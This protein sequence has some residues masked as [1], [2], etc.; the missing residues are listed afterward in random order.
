MTENRL[1]NVDV[2][3]KDTALVLITSIAGSAVGLIGCSVLHRRMLRVHDIDPVSI[4]PSSPATTICGYFLVLIGFAA[5]ALPSPVVEEMHSSVDFDVTLIRNTFISVSVGILGVI[6]LHFIFYRSNITYWVVL[7]FLQGGLAS[8][9]TISAGYDLYDVP[10]CIIVSLIGAICFFFTSEYFFTTTIEDNCNIIAIHFVCGIV[11][12]LL[13]PF[14]SRKGNLGFLNNPSV[15]MNMIHLAWQVL[16]CLA[17]LAL[18]FL[19]FTPIFLLLLSLHILRNKRE[20]YAHERARRVSKT[21]RKLIVAE[22][23]VDNNYILPNIDRKELEDDLE[24]KISGYGEHT[25]QKVF[26]NIGETPFYHPETRKSCSIL[27]LRR[28]SKVFQKNARTPKNKGRA[29]FQKCK[30]VVIK[31]PFHS[32]SALHK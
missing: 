31:N 21:G 32:D 3:F 9:I 4:G 18:I 19:T 24:M 15:Y 26:Q 1:D 8:F 30:N 20:I 16:C 12:C 14:F 27:K 7:K 13:P 23:N 10:M 2:S 5:L 28:P 17:A 25:T 29:R 6:V 11:S 22:P